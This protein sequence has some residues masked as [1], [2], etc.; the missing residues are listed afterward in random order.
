LF[1]CCA[2]AEVFED[3]I[4]EWMTEFKKY[5]AY[6]NPALAESDSSKES[7]VDQARGV[8]WARPLAEKSAQSAASRRRADAAC[9]RTRARR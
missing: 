2:C 9:T 1:P 5:L 8:A 4:E 3:H 6:N 7:V